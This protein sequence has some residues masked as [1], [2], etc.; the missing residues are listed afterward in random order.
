MSGWASYIEAL[1]ATGQVTQA[2]IF[3]HDGTVWAA[4]PGLSNVA[5]S[6]LVAVS[7]T[8]DNPYEAQSNGLKLMGLSYIL[9]RSTSESIYAKRGSSG[10]SA[11]KTKQGVVV[12]FYD[13]PTYPGRSTVEVEKIASFM[14]DNNV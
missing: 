9:L 5:S 12:G 3:G 6:E 4:S 13:A 11:A 1:T 7:K 2:I 14:R 10:F 8:F